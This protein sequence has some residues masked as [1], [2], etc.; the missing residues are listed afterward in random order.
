[1]FSCDFFEILDNTFFTEQLWGTASLN[2]TLIFKQL[3]EVSVEYLVV[4]FETPLSTQKSL[5]QPSAEA[6]VHMRSMK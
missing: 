4:F 5:Y 6:T 3:R 2:R 1:M